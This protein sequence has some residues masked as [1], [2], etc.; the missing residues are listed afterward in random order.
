M[1]DKFTFSRS[2]GNDATLLATSRIREK[3]DAET[4]RALYGIKNNLP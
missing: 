4:S 2:F 3:A 1:Q